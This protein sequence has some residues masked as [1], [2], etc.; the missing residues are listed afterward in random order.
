[1]I[2]TKQLNVFISA[3]IT[4]KEIMYS[5]NGVQESSNG[6]SDVTFRIKYPIQFT[7]DYIADIFTSYDRF[8]VNVDYLVNIDY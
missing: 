1:M 7:E 5:C 2:S 6:T 8:V 4:I 3:D